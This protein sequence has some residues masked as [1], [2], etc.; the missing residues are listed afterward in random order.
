MIFEDLHAVGFDFP[1]WEDLLDASL[2]REDHGAPDLGGW[3]FITPYT[4]PSG[5]RLMRYYLNEDWF[6]ATF[7][8]ATHSRWSA[9]VG[10]INKAVAMVDLLEPDGETY[11]RLT[12]NMDDAFLYPQLQATGDGKE[13]TV[14]VD[15]L[16]LAALA[17]D[18]NVFPDVEGWHGNEK[19]PPQIMQTP[20][21]P[22]NVFG[23]PGFTLC[24]WAIEYYRG[25]D[26]EGIMACSHLVLEVTSVEVRTNQLSGVP[27]QVARGTLVAECPSLEVCLPMDVGEVQAGSIIDGKVM[28]VG[29]SGV[30]DR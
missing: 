10:M 18:V 23:D 24:P 26:P 13:T 6:T 25:G 5:A 22:M 16:S 21:G 27:F 17:V 3:D 19:M 29:S 1:T 2:R 30:W 20:D 4:D 9:H 14:K 28:M 12:V 11:T 7:F 8:V 15:N